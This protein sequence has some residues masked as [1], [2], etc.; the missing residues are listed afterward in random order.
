MHAHKRVDWRVA[1]IA[2][3]L[4]ACSAGTPSAEAPSPQPTASAALATP[5]VQPWPPTFDIELRGTYAVDPP[6]RIP[7]TITIDDGGWFSG[8]LH[9]TFIDLQ[10]FDGITPHQFPNR[11]LGFADPDHVRGGTDV[12]V[13]GLTPDAAADLLAGRASLMTSNR[14]GQR[15]FGLGGVRIDV[16]S[17]TNSNPLFGNG[18]DHFGLGPQLDVRMVVLPRDLRLFVVC[19]LAAPGDLDAAWEQALPILE[20]VGLGP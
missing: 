1:A 8:H 12:D 18:A 15:L 6:F 4:A 13:S 7:F 16:H 19:V 17:A 2:L 20:T 14:V 10:R 5:R 9:D 11:M 3:T